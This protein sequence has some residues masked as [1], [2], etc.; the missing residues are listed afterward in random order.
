MGLDAHVYCNCLKDGKAK[1]LPKGVSIEFDEGYYY[2]YKDG[3]ELSWNYVDEYLKTACE[4]LNM[5][6][7]DDRIGNLSGLNRFAYILDG[8]G[9]KFDTIETLFNHG[10]C[11][12]YERVIKA[13]D[14]LQEL[15]GLISTLNGNFL[16]DLKDNSTIDYTIG[17]EEISKYMWREHYSILHDRKYNIFETDTDKLLFSSD[18]FIFY[19]HNDLNIFEDISSGKIFKTPLKFGYKI[20]TPRM[21]QVDYRKFSCNDIYTIDVLQRCFNTSIKSKNPIW[22]G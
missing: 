4:H 12:P 14:E 21:F 13:N 11:V 6:L 15:K 2:M 16:T 3:K 1:P 22:F 19:P 17:N 20:D 5:R 9:K 18:Y 7:F 8:C 10:N